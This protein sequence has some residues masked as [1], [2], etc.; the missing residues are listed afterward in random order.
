MNNILN[1]NDIVSAKENPEEIFDLIVLLGI[2]H[3]I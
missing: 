2:I 1:L 3:C